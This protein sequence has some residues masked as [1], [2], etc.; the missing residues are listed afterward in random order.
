M[1]L[2]IFKKRYQPSLS[3]LLVVVLLLSI[4]PLYNDFSTVF[5]ENE[6]GYTGYLPP[7]TS[8][9]S[10]NGYQFN[11]PI[12]RDLGLKVYGSWQAIPKERNTFKPSTLDPN[13]VI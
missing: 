11:E 3:I 12:W 4:F 10:S 7:Y 9:C 13:T 2:K 6:C 1:R 8:A 5:A